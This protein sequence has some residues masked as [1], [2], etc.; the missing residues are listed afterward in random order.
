MVAPFFSFWVSIDRDHSWGNAMNVPKPVVAAFTVLALLLIGVN[1]AL[2]RQDRALF[3]LNTAYEAKFHLSVGDMVPPLSGTGPN[4]NPAT[5]AYK[6]GQPKTLL[7]VFARSCPDCTLN[8][9]AWQNLVNQ[10]D[11]TRVR[12]VAVSVERAGLSSQYIQQAGL[13]RAKMVLLP[14]FESITSY[15]FQY[16]PQT[17]LIGSDGKVEGIWSGVLKSQQISEI[18]QAVLSP[19]PTSVAGKKSA[20]SQ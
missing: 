7:L 6:S 13:A 4:G 17:I 18:E 14:D 9:P 2:V 3:S 19:E 8:S 5:V 10:I 16:T 20:R 15:R 11:L 1:I 12:A